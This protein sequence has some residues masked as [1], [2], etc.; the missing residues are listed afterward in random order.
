MYVSTTVQTTKTPSDKCMSP[1]CGGH[2]SVIPGITI[3]I[4]VNHAAATGI[5]LIELGRL[6]GQPRLVFPCSMIA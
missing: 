4:V 6:C 3:L 1:P 2:W 5:G